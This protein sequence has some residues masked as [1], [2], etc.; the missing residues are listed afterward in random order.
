MDDITV[1]K[2]YRLKNPGTLGKVL[3]WKVT[4]K[5][6]VRSRIGDLHC[7]RVIS[8]PSKFTQYLDYAEFSKL[9]KEEE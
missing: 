3:R 7:V 9:F 6:V 4:A 1:G 2:F 5:F 8:Q